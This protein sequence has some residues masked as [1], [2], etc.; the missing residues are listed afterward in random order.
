MRN[1][2]TNDTLKLK[3]EVNMLTLIQRDTTN[4]N[5][6]KFHGYYMTKKVTNYTL[7]VTHFSLQFDFCLF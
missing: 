4:Y 2:N 5:W 3:K 6:K 7:S 1:I